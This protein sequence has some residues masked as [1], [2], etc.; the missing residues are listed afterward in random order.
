MS[1]ESKSGAGRMEK[2]EINEGFFDLLGLLKDW[3]EVGKMY[4]EALSL[5]KTEEW[6]GRVER[7]NDKVRRN[8]SRLSEKVDPRE[9]LPPP[10]D[11]FYNVS[12]DF[13]RLEMQLSLCELEY[14]EICEVEKGGGERSAGIRVDAGPAKSYPTDYY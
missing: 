8:N 7:Y 1:Q 14:K 12:D 9:P 4:D 10:E 5:E 2:R 6:R 13:N 3:R 11:L